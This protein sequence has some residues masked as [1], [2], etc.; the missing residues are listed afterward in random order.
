[1]ILS[2]RRYT[3]RTGESCISLFNNNPRSDWLN[4]LILNYECLFFC[5]LFLEGF[6][7]NISI[8]LAT[9]LDLIL[10]YYV[11]YIHKY[12]SLIRERETELNRTSDNHPPLANST[13]SERNYNSSSKYSNDVNYLAPSQFSFI[14]PNVVP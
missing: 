7:R 12:Y 11:V 4:L 10:L 8:S 1:M 2:E 13:N 9:F 5:P 3:C 6:I 14:D